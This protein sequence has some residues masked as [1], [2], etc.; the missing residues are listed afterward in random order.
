MKDS[1]DLEGAYR[2]RSVALRGMASSLSG[3]AR[4][5]M[6]DMAE[7]WET[8]AVQA[9]AV[10]RSKRLISAWEKT[11]PPKNGEANIEPANI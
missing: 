5:T 9:E 2:A 3:G 4:D 6:M 7:H 1:T 10:A 11:Q 8:L